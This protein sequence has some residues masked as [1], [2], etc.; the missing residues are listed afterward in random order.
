V[1]LETGETEEL[2]GR[3]RRAGVRAAGRGGAIRVSFHFYN[4]EE[5]V[6]RALE[7]LQVLDSKA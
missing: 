4:D 3:L 5:D 6:A 2:L 7:V 1:R